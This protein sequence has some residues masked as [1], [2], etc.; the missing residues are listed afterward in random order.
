VKKGDT[1]EIKGY[2]AD[3]KALVSEIQ[4]FGKVAGEVWIL[5]A[6]NGVYLYLGESW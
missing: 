1:L 4:L 6:W 2:D 5:L 3:I